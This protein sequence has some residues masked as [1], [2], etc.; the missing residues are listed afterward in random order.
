MDPLYVE[1]EQVAREMIGQYG[2]PAVLVR[3]GA[4]TGPEW[5]P[6]PGVDVPYAVVLLETRT[7]DRN[8]DSALVQQGDRIGLISPAVAVEPQMSDRLQLDGAEYHFV[9]LRPLNPGG[10][11]MFYRFLA[12]A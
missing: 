2:K 7:F 10:L 11:N 3:Q 4:P 8:R 1:L 6:V 9:E 5:E 12:R